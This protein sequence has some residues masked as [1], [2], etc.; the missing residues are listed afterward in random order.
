MSTPPSPLVAAVRAKYP[1]AYSDMDDTALEQAV[2]QKHPEYADMASLKGKMSAPGTFQTKRGGPTYNA[3]DLGS[4]PIAYPSLSA[5][6]SGAK[7]RAALPDFP[8]QVQQSEREEP[9]RAAETLAITGAPAT[10]LGAI[11]AP[12]ATAG[13]LA[14]GYLGQAGAGRMARA[15]HAS[16][17]TE[18]IARVA[19]GLAGGVA[20]GFAGGQIEL[21][22]KIRL[23]RTG[24]KIR[25]PSWMR[26]ADDAPKLVDKI[27]GMPTSAP[28]TFEAPLPEPGSV[29]QPRLV[30]KIAAPS[31]NYS[32]S[33]G[34][35]FNA[36]LP[37]PGSVPQPKLV[38]RIAQESGAGPQAVRGSV[39]KPSGRL[40]KLP[41]EFSSEDQLQN[42]ATDRAKK[43]GMQ[44]AG[45][46]RPSGGGRV[47]MTPT[48]TATPEAPA[49]GE[50]LLEKMRPYLEGQPAAPTVP[51]TLSEKIAY[52]PLSPAEH[53]DLEVEAGRPL[54]EDEAYDYIKR[55][56]QAGAV[57]NM[58]KGNRAAD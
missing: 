47:P 31:P 18:D 7:A 54:T 53:A 55:R 4:K 25:T 16:D 52:Q 26:T 14:G 48:G 8:Q 57:A 5:A 39:G 40:V 44:Y 41:E 34:S 51:R 27:A 30:D 15:F 29:P 21:P 32:T 10:I 45:G 6:V 58:L 28:S 2:L 46:M 49:R 9:A 3:N 12:V 36:Q 33:G 56:T 35:S 1:G 37:E 43:H 42:I 23:G 50:S 22:E 17:T 19:G 38:D 13:S 24:I 20:G 11:T